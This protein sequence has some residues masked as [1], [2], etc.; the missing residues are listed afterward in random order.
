MH[1]RARVS[2]PCFGSGFAN[3]RFRTQSS[4]SLEHTQSVQLYILP[5]SNNVLPPIS[6]QVRRP[7]RTLN[8]MGYS[9]LAIHGFK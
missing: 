1:T 7:P 6:T 8:L 9:G 2:C 4:P 3:N 5:L